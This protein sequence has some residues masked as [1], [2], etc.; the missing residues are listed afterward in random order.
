MSGLGI[1][2]PVSLFLAR[3]LFF[4]LCRSFSLCLCVS[5]SL[6]R[7]ISNQIKIRDEGLV[8]KERRS[9]GE[10]VTPGRP[11]SRSE[12]VTVIVRALNA[13]DGHTSALSTCGASSR[14]KGS[15]AHVGVRLRGLSS[16]GV[17]VR[18]F[19]S[20]GLRLRR[21]RSVGVSLRGFMKG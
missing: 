20:A 21:I 17:R 4:S 12:S 5:L 2:W 18:G 14:G 10:T 8:L 13:G 1:M 3:S 9:R 11:S 7:S 16:V 15:R 6:S 19:I